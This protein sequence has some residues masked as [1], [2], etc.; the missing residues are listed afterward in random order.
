MIKSDTVIN[1]ILIKY[2]KA[3]EV[4]KQFGIRCFGW[5][6]VLYKSVGYA[7]KTHGIDEEKLI[8][9]LKNKIDE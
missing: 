1:D 7:A 5:G 2:P 4:L 6:G 3:E 9:T 8:E